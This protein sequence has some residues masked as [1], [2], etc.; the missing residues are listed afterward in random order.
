MQMKAAAITLAVFLAGCGTARVGP[1]AAAPA[2]RVAPATPVVGGASNLVDVIGIYAGADL[3]VDLYG[4]RPKVNRFG[5]PLELYAFVRGDGRRWMG[6][7]EFV[8]MLSGWKGDRKLAVLNRPVEVEGESR[9]RYP[10]YD[11]RGTE[12]SAAEVSRVERAIREAG[13]A[14]VVVQE[15]LPVHVFRFGAIFGVGAYPEVPLSFKVVRVVSDW[16]RGVWALPDVR[17]LRL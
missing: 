1:N 14:R 4:E 6:R 10:P 9:W 13:F 15:I 7:D 2:A 17:E 8:L 11:E 5:E 12:A 3:T 16:S